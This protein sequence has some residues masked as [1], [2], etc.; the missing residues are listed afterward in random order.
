ML[1]I[2]MVR[3]HPALVKVSEKKR[4]HDLSIVDQ[5]LKLDDD[6]RKELKITEE[7]N[8]KRNVVSEE[9]N[10]SKKK[11][12][13]KTAQKKI[14][15]MR[16]IIDTIKANEKETDHFLCK[17]NSELKKIGNVLHESVPKGKDDS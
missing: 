13:E 17:R 7:L 15:E 11:K 6:W 1:D 2:K 8:R 3:E 12:D 9:I 16:E 4:N 5:V 10:Q 14:K